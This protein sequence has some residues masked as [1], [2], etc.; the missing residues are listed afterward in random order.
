MMGTLPFEVKSEYRV[1][2]RITEGE[3]GFAG[4]QATELYNGTL[5]CHNTASV[6]ILD[7]PYQFRAEGNW[8]TVFL[9]VKFEDSMPDGYDAFLARVDIG[10]NFPDHPMFTL[11]AL[12]DFGSEGGESILS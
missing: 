5:H 7:R 9:R 11:P 2:V 1:T 4:G 12:T 8:H 3:L 6:L 10:T